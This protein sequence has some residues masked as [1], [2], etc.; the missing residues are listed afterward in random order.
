MNKGGWI[1]EIKNRG[2]A[3]GAVRL[4][5]ASLDSVVTD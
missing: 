3:A 4:V 2:Q 5:G 1:A